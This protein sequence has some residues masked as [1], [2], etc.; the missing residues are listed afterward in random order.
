MTLSAGDQAPDFTLSDQDGT[1]RTLSTLL[2]D[3]P[4][5]LFFYPAALSPGCTRESCHFRDLAKEFADV[6]GQRIGISTDEVDKQKQFADKH[7]FDY[8][9]LADTDGKVAEA[10][11]VRRGLLG[12]FIP[13]KRATFVIDTDRTILTVVSSETNMNKHADAALSALAGRAGAAG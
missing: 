4:V 9:L 3:G 2:Q 7:S 11:G 13:V 6:G 8:P 10:F 5:V 12:K 1:S